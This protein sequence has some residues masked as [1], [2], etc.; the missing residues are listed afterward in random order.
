MQS[1]EEI[2]MVTSKVSEKLSHTLNE[3][4]E[5]LLF[6]CKSYKIL[7]DFVFVFA[8]LHGY[9]ILVRLCP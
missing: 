5:A 2:I 9:A 3:E 6:F 1:G 7:F 8:M 4:S